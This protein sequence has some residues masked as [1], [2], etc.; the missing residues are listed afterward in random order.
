MGFDGALEKVF[1]ADPDNVLVVTEHI[2]GT[3][4][5]FAYPSHILSYAKTCETDSSY[6]YHSLGERSWSIT[7][8]RR[9]RTSPGTTKQ[10]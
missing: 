5:R 1:A 2:P 8:S 10:P 4:V 9:D 6:G 7:G 3:V